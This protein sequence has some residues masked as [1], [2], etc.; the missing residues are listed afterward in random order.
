MIHNQLIRDCF[1]R[2]YKLHLPSDGPTPKQIKPKSFYDE[3]STRTFLH[4]MDVSESYWRQLSYQLVSSLP[5]TANPRDYLN[6]IVRLLIQGRI[7]LFEINEIDTK[8]H[9]I[10]K[11]TFKQLNGK[12]YQIVPPVEKLLNPNKKTKKF[13]SKEEVM[14]LVKK[15]SPEEES[16]HDL[17][18][19]FNLN[20]PTSNTQSNKQEALLESIGDAVIEE[21]LLIFEDVPNKP[22]VPEPVYEDV[23]IK[24]VT[25]GP[26]V[27][28]EW[29]N[30]LVKRKLN[31]GAVIPVQSNIRIG[32]HNQGEMSA[33]T[34][35]NGA[36][37][38]SIPYGK[39]M[40]DIKEMEIGSDICYE[41]ISLD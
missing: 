19:T 21:N 34:D 1:G 6:A 13:S 5:Y 20:L 24:P 9:P 22:P 33:T 18:T 17:A 16:L 27:T 4:S 37:Q 38:M 23:H 39:N 29:L 32:L 8:H 15:L 7:Q 11:R 25:L 14:E 26:D 10:K 2:Q 35:K 12:I 3:T 28:E 41:F 31:N 30:I 40:V 36:A